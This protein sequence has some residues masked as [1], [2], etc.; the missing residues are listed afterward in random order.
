MLFIYPAFAGFVFALFFWAILSRLKPVWIWAI[1]A[2]IFVM[3]LASIFEMPPP[4]DGPTRPQEL[5]LIVIVPIL[6]AVIPT[7]AVNKLVKNT[8]RPSFS[9]LY[10]RAA[11]GF[12][13]GT[14]LT[15]LGILVFAPVA[16]VA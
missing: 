11:F 15:V 7:W 12:V 1:P 8:P 9:A 5:E 4:P 6:F 10:R 16:S 13:P 2:L 3:G 14:V